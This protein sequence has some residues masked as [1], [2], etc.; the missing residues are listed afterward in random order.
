MDIQGL[1]A[2]NDRLRVRVAE[3][4]DILD[5]IPAMVYINQC[6]ETG[7]IMGGHNVWS[8][9]RTL[10][11]VGYTQTEIDAMGFSY[12]EKMMDAEEMKKGEQSVEFLRGVGS[13]Q[14]F[15]GMAHA[16]LHGKRVSY[17]MQTCIYKS[18]PEGLPY[19]HLS[20]GFEIPDTI[21]TQEQL[22]DAIREIEQLKH[23]LRIQ[24]L[25]ARE[26]EVL[27][28]I[29]KGLTD[30]EIGVE[31]N[32]SKATAHTHRNTLVRKTETGNTAALVAFAVRCGL[33]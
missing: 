21:N 19:Q 29:A 14:I 23:R 30:A 17:Y 7:S 26:R 6:G 12:Y 9:Q 33:D 5:K 18:T 10:D 32:I 3:L 2:E 1:Q 13:D 25:S 15:R 24:S 8:N 31:L 11:F 27:K 20:A 4:E 16:N 28:L 22:S